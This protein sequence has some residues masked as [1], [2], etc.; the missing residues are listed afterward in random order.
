MHSTAA[1]MVINVLYSILNTAPISNKIFYLIFFPPGNKP[2]S[3]AVTNS[4]LFCFLINFFKNKLV[5][6]DILI[7]L[8][9]ILL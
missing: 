8:F 7:S 1:P 2:Y 6:F 9:I 5:S 4:V 3:M